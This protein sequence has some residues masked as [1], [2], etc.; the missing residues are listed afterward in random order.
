MGHYYYFIS[1]LP[2]LK[3][4]V[5]S[6][7]SV[8]LY[9]S[10]CEKYGIGPR[11]LKALSELSLLPPRQIKLPANSFQAKWYNWETYLRN[12]LAIQRAQLQGKMVRSFLL[13]Q[14]DEYLSEIDRI[15]NETLFQA[16]VYEREK[17]LD[18]LRWHKVEELEFGHYFDFD[19]LCSY[20][21]KL[22]I[23]EKWQRHSD[24]EK[25]FQKLEEIV[26]STFSAFSGGK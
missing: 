6:A 10:Q 8:R 4:D 26:S 5:P 15:V 2:S 11:I 14:K 19:I 1:S 13:P 9:L 7:M 18:G 3:F 22:L 12:R 20:K 25:G 17:M 16:P 24:T 21:L 23:K